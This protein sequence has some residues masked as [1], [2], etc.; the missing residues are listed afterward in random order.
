[1]PRGP[2]RCLQL[3][4]TEL[5]ANARHAE[6]G[7][8]QARRAPARLPRNRIAHMADL[9]VVEVRIWEQSVGAVASLHGKPGFY[10]FQYA[11]AF[12]NSGLELSPLHMPLKAKKR[13]SFPG[14]AQDTF[15]GLPGLLAD[16]LPDKF[17]NALIDE[18]LT[19]HGTRTDEITTLQRLVYVGRRAMGAL[20]FEPA[21]AHTRSAAMIVALD[22]AHLV[23]D[24]R[25]ALR[26]GLGEI[27]QEILD[28]GSSAGGA[29][30]KA[31]I[32]WNPQNNEIVSGQ[33]DLPRGYEHWLLK[34]DVGSDGVLGNSAGF[35]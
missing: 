26:G 14:L 27:A 28:I 24:A 6:A 4:K 30:A 12:E 9:N 31:V 34:F 25:R 22:M 15:H 19:R 13:F 18:Y 7:H 10:E 29:R 21:I 35:G 16:A 20:E 5:A 3:R 1:M 32:G 8:A 17:G 23:E 11:P 33:F 2:W